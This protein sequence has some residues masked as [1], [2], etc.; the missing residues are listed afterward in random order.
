MDVRIDQLKQLS[1][2]LG[3]DHDLA[4]LR[5]TLEREG[6]S[7][8]EGATVLHCLAG[9]RQE[10]LRAEARILGQRIYVMNT[11]CSIDQLKGL[12]KIWKG[13]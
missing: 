9:R 6:A 2:L 4:V 11:D 5:G 12:W 3:D 13:G 10:E 7:F 1:D 8:G